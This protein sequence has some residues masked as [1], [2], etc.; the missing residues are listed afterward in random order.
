MFGELELSASCGS[1][2]RPNKF[3][4]SDRARSCT[5]ERTSRNETRT[6]GNALVI[7]NPTL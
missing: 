3:K 7:L 2:L 4:A 6:D 1:V 5:F